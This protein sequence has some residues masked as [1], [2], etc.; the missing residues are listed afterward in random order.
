M[1]QIELRN[2]TIRLKDGF[3]GTAA[4]AQTVDPPANADTTLIIDTI[5]GTPD[6]RTTVP[7]GARFSVVGSTEDAYTVTEV[8]NNEV[9]RV[10]VD[11]TSGTF[12]LTYSAQ[13][14]SALDFDATAQEVEDA[15]VALSNIAPG[16]VDVTSPAAQTW[17]I[18]FKGT[19]AGTN[20]AQ[21]TATDV[22]LMGGGDTVT[23]S[24]INPAGTTWK[25]TF[26]PALA[27]AAGIPADNAVI[28][29]LPVQIDIRIGEGNLTWTE[30]R[31]YE[32]VLDRGDLDGVRE[33]D[34]QPL[35]LN[36]EFIYEFYTA[37]AADATFAPTP[38]DFL[39]KQGD[40]SDL[41]STSSDPCEPFAIDVEIFYEPP[42]GSEDT[43]RVI[44]PDFRYESLEFDLREATIS[45]SGRCNAVEPTVTRE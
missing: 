18:E 16:D 35:E 6:D 32:Y 20:V 24:T 29:F 5:A 10:I 19:F 33:G 34:Q 1:A 4:V 42:C 31:E 7:V 22:D 13:T 11:A 27:T 45:V 8:I 41:S 38:V 23:T 26:S 9:Q 28:T 39:K 17:Y 21:I 15:L 36:L 12:T 30:A 40:A 43:E 3:G 2:A 44:F 14:T 25:L 37:G